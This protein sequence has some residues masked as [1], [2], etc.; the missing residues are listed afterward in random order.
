MFITRRTLDGFNAADI[1]GWI[2][3]YLI[4]SDSLRDDFETRKFRNIDY[5][6]FVEP[7]DFGFVFDVDQ[8]WW[9]YFAQWEGTSTG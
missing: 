9:L 3:R 2:I 5:V 1:S 8:S 6:L 7:L 4:K